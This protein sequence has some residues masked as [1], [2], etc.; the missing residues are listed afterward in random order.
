MPTTAATI[1]IT[2]TIESLVCF[3]ETARDSGIGPG[4][5]SGSAMCNLFHVDG[6][7]AQM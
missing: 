5:I 6:V 2:Q 1:G 7:P 3:L 4:G